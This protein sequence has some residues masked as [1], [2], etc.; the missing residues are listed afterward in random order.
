MELCVQ[1]RGAQVGQHLITTFKAQSKE[2]F[3]QFRIILRAL[4]H[5][6]VPW[7]SKLVC[8]CAVAYLASPIQLIPSFIPVIGQMDDV[9]V[10]ALSIKLLKR[11]A[12]SLFLDNS[13]KVEEGQK[14]LV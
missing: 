12:P 9:L 7:S 13:P 4:R 3:R 10:I 5:P 1:F 2:L 8:G 11:S 14:V 6:D